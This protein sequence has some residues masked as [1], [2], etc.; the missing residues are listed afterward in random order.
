MSTDHGTVPSSPLMADEQFIR[1]AARRFVR[2][3]S[4]RRLRRMWR[5][6]Y[7]DPVT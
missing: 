2:R 1:A 5:R 7:R 3:H 6:L 4:D